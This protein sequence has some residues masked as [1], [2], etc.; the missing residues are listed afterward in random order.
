MPRPR[1]G[2][3]FA[4]RLLFSLP[5]SLSAALLLAA[6]ALVGCK[7]ESAPSSTAAEVVSS[8]TAATAPPAAEA[9]AGEARQLFDT[10]CAICHGANGHGD[11]P[12]AANLNPRPRNYSDKAWQASVT[13]EELR[14]IILLGGAAVGKSA[15]MPGQPQL[16]D[17]PEVLSALV[18]IIR[19][20]GK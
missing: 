15:T 17:K 2:Q 9:G 12:A 7:K 14:Q 5:A 11:G 6:V 1:L 19:G 20:F 16:K 13:D 8:T 10:T 4:T 3:T 18:G